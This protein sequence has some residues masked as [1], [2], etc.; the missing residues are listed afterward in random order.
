MSI[1]PFGYGYDACYGA[2]WGAYPAYTTYGYG[3]GYPAYGYG[4]GYGGYG[5]AY[6]R[7]D[8]RHM[9]KAGLSPYYW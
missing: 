6:S 8:L 7:R 5:S 4:Y 9:R 1:V 2:G 3:Y